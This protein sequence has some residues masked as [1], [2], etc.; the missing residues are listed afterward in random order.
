MLP[1]S[2]AGVVERDGDVPPDAAYCGQSAVLQGTS[3][4]QSVAIAEPVKCDAEGG[5]L[6]NL[7]DFFCALSTPQVEGCDSDT[8]GTLALADR[9]DASMFNQAMIRD[10]PGCPVVSVSSK[11][12]VSIDMRELDAC[13]PGAQNP[14]CA[15]PGGFTMGGNPNPDRKGAWKPRLAAARSAWGMTRLPPRVL[16]SCTACR[17]SISWPS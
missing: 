7:V 15:Q 9:L 3:F 14:K 5:F 2:T 17:G 13:P 4:D 8:L 11:G 12:D 1:T 10:L 16:R 6:V